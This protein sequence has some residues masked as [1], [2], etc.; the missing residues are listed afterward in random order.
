MSG[1]DTKSVRAFQE[2]LGRLDNPRTRPEDVVRV[3][4]P[5][6]SDD[7]LRDTEGK[8]WRQSEGEVVD[9]FECAALQIRGTKQN[10]QSVSK[11]KRTCRV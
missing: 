6:L 11:S 5:V 3:R 4:D 7:F 1:R 8:C 9:L 2:L 10:V